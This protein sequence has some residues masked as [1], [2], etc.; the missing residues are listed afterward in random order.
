MPAA[1]TARGPPHGPPELSPDAGRGTQQIAGKRVARPAAIV[2][3]AYRNGSLANLPD[4]MLIKLRVAGTRVLLARRGDQA[5]AVADRCA[6]L[7]A[8]LTRGG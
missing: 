3:P 2:R 4:G 7:G 5:Y 8:P 6:H 1:Q